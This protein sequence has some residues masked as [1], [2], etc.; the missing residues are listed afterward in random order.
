MSQMNNN[1][2]PKN[3]RDKDGPIEETAHSRNQKVYNPF[4]SHPV[5]KF[6]NSLL[7]YSMAVES[8]ST[9]SR[10]NDD[11]PVIVFGGFTL[12]K[13][14]S[15]TE[16]DDGTI[17]SQIEWFSIDVPDA[18]AD[19]HCQKQKLNPLSVMEIEKECYFAALD[20]SIY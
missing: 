13:Q 20:S 15:E 19:S 6:P 18:D 11:R 16:R 1:I 7:F 3:R 12:D 17:V 8:S 2:D 4:S 9:K 14:R 10:P 5:H